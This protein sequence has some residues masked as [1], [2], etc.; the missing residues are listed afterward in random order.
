[1]GSLKSSLFK[2]LPLLDYA[3]LPLETWQR[4]MLQV[5]SIRV[6]HLAGL[7]KPDFY[8][9]AFALWNTIPQRLD[10]HFHKVKDMV[11]SLSWGSGCV[12]DI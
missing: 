9:M 8:V 6:C 7:R 5:L 10:R 2:R 11:A 4:G 1:M 3:Y 12:A